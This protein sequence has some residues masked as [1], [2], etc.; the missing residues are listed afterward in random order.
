VGGISERNPAGRIG[1]ALI[2]AIQKVR[3][4]VALNALGVSSSDVVGR[5]NRD[6]EP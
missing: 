5:P 6:V 3:S 1:L 4:N 2:G